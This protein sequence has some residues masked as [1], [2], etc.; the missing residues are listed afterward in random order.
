MFIN[1]V[2]IF[3]NLTRDPELKALPS[4]GKVCN[5]SVATNRKYKKA[6]DS[7]A[8]EVEFHSVVVYGKVAENCERYLKKGGSVF[9]EGHLRTRTWEGDKGKQNK[10][11]LIAESVQFGPRKDGAKPEA[12]EDEDASSEDGVQF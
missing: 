5:F 9:V 2:F 12:S 11:E 8:E 10:T 4:G 6:D 1:K 7:V 3:G